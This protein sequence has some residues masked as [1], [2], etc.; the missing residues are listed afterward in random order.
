M[1]FSAAVHVHVFLRILAGE[2]GDLR[3]VRR[4]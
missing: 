3:E 1:I 4:F 2:E